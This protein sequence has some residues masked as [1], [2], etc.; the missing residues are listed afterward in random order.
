[1]RLRFSVEGA[2]FWRTG[3]PRRHD[4]SSLFNAFGRIFRPPPLRLRASDTSV[5][6]YRAGTTQTAGL[7]SSVGRI[8]KEEAG[9]A[10]KEK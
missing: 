9:V 5:L 10:R 8:E 1:M 3:E 6:E 2:T 7:E 4:A